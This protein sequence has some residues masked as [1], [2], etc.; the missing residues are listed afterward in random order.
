ML[1]RFLKETYQVTFSA[2]AFIECHRKEE[3][4]REV[5]ELIDELDKF[6]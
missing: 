1:N 2:N 4:L 6:R 5:L 3:A